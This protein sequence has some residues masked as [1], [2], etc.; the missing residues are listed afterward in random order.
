MQLCVN[1]I[2]VFFNLSLSTITMQTTWTYEMDAQLTPRNIQLSYK[3]LKNNQPPLF[4]R[5]YNR[6]DIKFHI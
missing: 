1:H 2:L 4:F 5:M 6:V 3:S